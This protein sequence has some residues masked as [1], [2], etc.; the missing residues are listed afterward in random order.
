VRSGQTALFLVAEF[1]KVPGQFTHFLVC[2]RVVGVGL[3]IFVRGFGLD[4]IG[5][6]F[7]APAA[8]VR[9]LLLSPPVRFESFRLCVY[10]FR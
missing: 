1:V 10:Y 2:A 8:A 5:E 4:I 9:E 6:D 7:S 3:V